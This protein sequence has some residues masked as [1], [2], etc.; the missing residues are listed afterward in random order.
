[1]AKKSSKGRTVVGLDIE[2]SYVAAAEVRNGSGIAVERAV[3]KSLD[4]GVMRDGEVTDPEALSEALRELFS[5]HKLPKRV[6]LGVAN[7]KIVVR[8]IELPKIEGEKELDA[9]IRFQAQEHIPMPL[10]EAVMDYHVLGNVMTDAGERQRIMVVA[11]RRDMIERLLS[12]ARSA[13]L[14]PEGIDLSAFAMIRALGAPAADGSTATL[15]VNVGGLTNLAVADATYCHFVRVASGGIE[16]MATQLAE[17]RGL[18]LEHSR[19]WLSHVGLQA[20]IDAIEGDPEIV[21]DARSVLAD[22]TRRIADDVRNSLDFYRA[23]VDAMVVER[24]VVTGP[25][26]AISGFTN[27][28]SLDLGMP[29]DAGSVPEATPGALGGVEAGR[30]TVAAGLAVEERV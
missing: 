16:S 15:F 27:Q 22:G 10:D 28:L 9:A 14:R 11:A 1:M 30:V 19:Q 12:T 21:S 6:R 18:T 20:P 5:E 25:A 13:G 2:P 4:P 17:R 26:V 29:V 23:Q 24:A 8:T 3:S 7:Q